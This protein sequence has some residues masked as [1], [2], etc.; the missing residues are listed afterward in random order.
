M[1]GKQ[2]PTFE[3]AETIAYQLIDED[4]RDRLRLGS[5]VGDAVKVLTKVS[6]Y[7]ADGLGKSITTFDVLLRSRLFYFLQ[8]KNT[9]LFYVYKSSRLCCVGDRPYQQHNRLGDRSIH[10]QSLF[11]GRSPIQFPTKLIS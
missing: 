1:D 7:V 3:N 5:S 11:I 9:I 4:V 6:A 8:V 2:V 10:F